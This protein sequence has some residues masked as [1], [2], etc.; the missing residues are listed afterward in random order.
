MAMIDF[1]RQPSASDLRWF[2]AI[3]AAVF[4]ILGGV[5]ALRLGIGTA[6]KVLWSVGAGLAL[7]YYAVRPLRLP[8]YLGWMHA[9]APLGWVVSHLLLAII[10]FGVLTPLAL[11]MRAFGRDALDQAFVA[12]AATYWTPHPPQSDVSRYLRQT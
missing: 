6:P 2:G 1:R 8:M 7:L 4:A 10:Y 9:V 12:S 5:I 3:L 11:V